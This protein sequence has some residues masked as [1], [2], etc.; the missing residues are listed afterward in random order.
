MSIAF[1]ALAWKSEF[2]SGAKMVLL[3]LCDNANDQGECYPSIASICG[4]CSM[5]ERTVQG[6]INTLEKSGCLT[7]V[8]RQGRS[9]V[10]TIDPRRICTP[11]NLHPAESAPTPA[12]SAPTHA[13]SAPTVP[14]ES[15][16]RIIIE[17][18]RNRQRTISARS[19]EVQSVVFSV[20][21]VD[22]TVWQDFL[23]LRKTKKAPLTKTAV[24]G[25]RR[26]AEKAGMTFEA[27]LSE[28]CARGWVGF[29]ADWVAKQSHG[30][31]ETFAER[32]E[33]NAKEKWQ[34]MTGQQHPDL[35]NGLPQHLN[36]IEADTVRI[37]A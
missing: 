17:P 36:I 9:T 7:R 19:A 32:D 34:R 5:S 6:H 28:C 2:S 29:K 22:K 3:S 30:P 21:D 11:Q 15:A 25:I 4:R 1:M 37:A 26:E 20:D 33:R 18:S 31:L 8:E 10:Y 16:P 24:D 27:A 23:A 12:E 35:A 14:A 13:E